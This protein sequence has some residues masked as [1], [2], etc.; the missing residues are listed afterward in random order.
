MFV[1][2]K[3]GV[4]TTNRYGR[5]HTGCPTPLTTSSFLFYRELIA[6]VFIS[7]QLTATVSKNF[8]LPYNLP[9]SFL[10]GDRY[11]PVK[12]LLLSAGSNAC[13]YS[14]QTDSINR[15]RALNSSSPFA[16]CN[17]CSYKRRASFR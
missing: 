6:P 10:K 17:A 2:V 5:I 15:H 13:W 9:S 7:G 14:S 12:V 3:Q 8:V 4:Y 16:S 1:Y 11:G